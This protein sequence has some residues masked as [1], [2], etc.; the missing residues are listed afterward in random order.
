[1]HSP[2]DML[3]STQNVA[4]SNVARSTLQLASQASIFVPLTNTPEQL[5][6]YARGYDPKSQWHTSALQALGMESMT[7]F[8]RQHAQDN[9]ATLDHCANT[10]NADGRHPIVHMQY[11]LKD[12]ATNGS[13]SNAT[14]CSP[15]EHM[16]NASNDLTR[17]ASGPIDLSPPAVSVGRA[18]TPPAT[19][20]D[21]ASAAVMRG[22]WHDR[23]SADHPADDLRRT[24]GARTYR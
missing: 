4:T 11:E 17:V 15:R 24:Q 14:T 3:Q 7:L 1:M 19:N 5:P 2:A 10:L 6:Q 23:L 18:R 9:T 8:S 20:R 21:H 12:P 13:S 16:E 22:A